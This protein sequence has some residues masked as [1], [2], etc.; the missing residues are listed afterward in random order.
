VEAGSG[1]GKITY[2][3][4]DVKLESSSDLQSAFAKNAFGRNSCY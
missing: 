1:A 3:V 2:Y 4:T